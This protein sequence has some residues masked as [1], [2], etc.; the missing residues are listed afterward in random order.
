MFL[1]SD[2]QVRTAVFCS[3]PDG[4][5]HSFLWIRGCHKAC[6]ATCVTKVFV[7]QFV[8]RVVVLGCQNACVRSLICICGVAHAQWN[9]GCC[10]ATPALIFTCVL[11]MV[12]P[13]VA[14]IRTIVRDV[15]YRTFCPCYATC[16][17]TVLRIVCECST[18]S[19]TK[20]TNPYLL[21][22]TLLGR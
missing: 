8:E 9:F 11:A 6:L 21:C 14:R 12:A 18:V 7:L 4:D 13:G 15:V 16:L 10:S 1:F 5:E 17:V 3:V 19:M 22:V 2:L 20:R